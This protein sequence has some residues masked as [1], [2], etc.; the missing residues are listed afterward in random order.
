[1]CTSTIAGLICT[2]F[3]A[4]LDVT[5]VLMKRPRICML[6]MQDHASKQCS[7]DSTT[8]V[9]KERSERPTTRSPEVI[10]PILVCSCILYIKHG[11]DTA[12][13]AT[14]LL[15]CRAGGLGIPWLV[16][17]QG[18]AAAE[19]H[20]V[21]CRSRPVHGAGAT[22]PRGGDC[23]GGRDVGRQPDFLEII[24]RVR[25]HYHCCCWDRRDCRQG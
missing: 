10:H 8:T 2:S 14:Q 4:H 21:P 22:S 13:R 19:S 5:A 9:G 12:I 1:M 3:C 17:R 7:I 23:R 6:V 20:R 24:F 18:P 11:T 25:L 15:L 16:R